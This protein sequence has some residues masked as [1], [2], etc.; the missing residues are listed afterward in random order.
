[1]SEHC[2]FQVFLNYLCLFDLLLKYVV[3]EAKKK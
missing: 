3:E 2:P 1:M